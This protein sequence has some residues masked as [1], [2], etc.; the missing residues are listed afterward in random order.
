MLSGGTH[1]ANNWWLGSTFGRAYCTL[2]DYDRYR[3]GFADVLN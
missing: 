1:S 2:F 3:V